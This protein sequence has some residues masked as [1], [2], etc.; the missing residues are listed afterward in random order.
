MAAFTC[1]STN[2]LNEPTYS[3]RSERPLEPF[4]PELSTR[5]LQLRDD[6]RMTVTVFQKVSPGK[7]A[8]L[9]VIRRHHMGVE[10]QVIE[11]ELNCFPELA[12]G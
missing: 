1:S 4:K 5:S 6:G 12:D 8:T 9:H 3:H 2:A 11:G 7:V 10:L